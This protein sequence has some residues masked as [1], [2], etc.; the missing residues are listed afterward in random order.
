ML[1]SSQFRPPNPPKLYSNLALLITASACKQ[2]KQIAFFMTRLH[3]INE[4]ITSSVMK[5][6]LLEVSLAGMASMQPYILQNPAEILLVY[7]LDSSS[8]PTCTRHTA[9]MNQTKQLY[10]AA[11]NNSTNGQFQ[12]IDPGIY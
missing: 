8:C 3:D 6:T 9:T 12:K 7:T 10:Q 1:Y 2:S 11:S 4:M 5:E